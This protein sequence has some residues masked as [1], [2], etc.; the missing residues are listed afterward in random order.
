MPLELREMIPFGAPASNYLPMLLFFPKLTQYGNAGL[1]AIRA[2]PQVLNELG[3]PE[4]VVYFFFAALS[5]AETSQAAGARRREH[6]RRGRAG[7]FRE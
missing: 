4:C 7:K 5:H 6:N 2:T 1:I 3:P